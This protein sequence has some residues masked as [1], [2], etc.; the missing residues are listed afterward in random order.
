MGAEPVGKDQGRG[1]GR[2]EQRPDQE[3]LGRGRE[4]GRGSYRQGGAKE[5][6]KQEKTRVRFEF[7]NISVG[8][9]M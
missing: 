4:D 6:C 8:S 2:S 9:G 7:E 1:C 5:V 3:G